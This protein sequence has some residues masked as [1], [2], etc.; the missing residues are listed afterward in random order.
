MK[1]ICSVVQRQALIR[2]WLWILLL[3]LCLPTA[4]ASVPF[5]GGQGT[6]ESPYQISNWHHLHAVR[7]YLDKSFILTAD[8][9]PGTE[10]YAERVKNGDNLAN[11]GRGWDPI[12]TNNA[13]NRFSGHFDGGGKTIEGLVL[14]APSSQVLGLFGETASDAVIKN[15]NLVNVDIDGFFSVGALVGVHR[16]VLEEVAA[17]GAV[18]GFSG[19]GGL[20]GRN[21][22]L[23][24]SS[25]A[26]ASV[27]PASG[28]TTLSSAGGAVGSNEASGTLRQVRA[29]SAVAAVAEFGG[30]V[31][32]NKGVVED[33]HA[34]GQVEG[35]SGT[36]QRVGGF[37]GV[38]EGTVRRSGAAGDVIGVIDVGGFVGVNSAG[39]IED[40]Y[41]TVS[42]NAVN[43]ARV[44]GFAGDNSNGGVIR[45]AYSAGPVSVTGTTPQGPFV[46]RNNGT[47]TASLWNADVNSGAVGSLNGGAIGAS[48][49]ELRSRSRFTTSFENNAWDFSAVWQIKEGQGNVFSFPYL[50]GVSYDTPF[51]TPSIHP[52][53]GLVNEPALILIF[54]TNKSAG[55]AIQ[56][57]FLGSVNVNID[58]GDG[59]NVQSVN[60]AGVVSRTYAQE[61]RYT[62]R[63]S[64]SLDHFGVVVSSDSQNPLAGADKLVQVFSF[65]NLGISSLEGAFFGAANLTQ[66]PVHL[67]ATVTNLGSAFERAAL[68]N[69]DL[70]VWDVSAVTNMGRMFRAASAF[71]GSGLTAWDIRG[72]VHLGSGTGLDQ[73]LSDTSLTRENYDAL[74]IAW[75][76][77]PVV[78]GDLVLG[79]VPTQYTKGP[80]SIARQALIDNFG[81]SFSDSSLNLFADG[82]GSETDPFQIANWAHLNAVRN[83]LESHFILNNDLDEAS[84]G[85]A[86]FVG[87]SEGWSPIGTSTQL[88]RGV[89]N[90]DGKRIRNLRSIRPSA[91]HVALFAYV[92]D[93]QIHDLGLLDVDVHG[94][95]WSASLAADV[96]G[97]SQIARVFA[98]GQ[99]KTQYSLAGGLVARCIGSLS[100]QPAIS[101]VYSLVSVAGGM[102]GGPNDPS[103]NFGGIAGNAP[104]CPIA[105][106]YSAGVVTGPNAVGGLVGGTVNSLISDSYWDVEASGLGVPN[107]NNAGAIGKTTSQMRQQETFAAWDF[108]AIWHIEAS[109][110]SGLRSYPRLRGFEY[111]EPF[112]AP[113]VNPIPGLVIDEAAM[114][115]R[116]DTNLGNGTTIELSLQG[117]VN[118][119]VD[120]GDGTK[121]VINQP[122]RVS[123]TYSSDGEYQVIILGTLTHFGRSGV[124]NATNRLP[125]TDML[126][127][128]V[129]FGDL[130]LESLAAAFLGAENLLGVAED[131]PLSVTNLR[132]AFEGAT[133]FNG[134]ITGWSVSNVTD[135]SRM[136]FGASSFN[137]PIG[138]WDVSN[139]T[140]FSSM[141]FEASSFNAN[142]ASWDVG[143]ATTFFSMFKGAIAFEGHGLAGWNT[144]SVT[145]MANMFYLA[146]KF[147]AD[148]ALWNVSKVRNMLGMFDGASEFDSVVTL[149]DVSNVT[150][151]SFMFND[152]VSFKG[153]GL[154][155]WD[156]SNVTDMRF[157]FKRATVLNADLSAWDVGNVTNMTAMFSLARQFNSD[158]GQWNVSQVTNMSGMFDSATAF[159][160]F[161]LSAWDIG[162]VAGLVNMLT[163]SALTRA[164]YDA[165]L[166]AWSQLPSV[167]I[168][169]D[170]GTVP[171]QYTVGPA[172]I[173][174]QALI[175]EFAWTIADNGGLNLFAAGTG[176]EAAPFL[177]ANWTQLNEVRNFPDAHF[178]LNG[179][180]DQGTP[181]YSAVVGHAD[182]WVPIGTPNAPF[183]S[184]FDGAGFEI[185]DLVINRPTQDNIGLF[186]VV[187]SASIKNL[188]LTD[189]DV[190]GRF[191]VGVLAGSVSGE[192]LI[193]GVRV[194]QGQAIG[195]GRVGGLVGRVAEQAT[196]QLS[197]ATGTVRGGRGVGGLIGVM[198]GDGLV[199]RSFATG[200][201]WAEIANS[202]GLIG[203][204][205]NLADLRETAEVRNVYATGQVSGANNAGGLIG[206][207][208]DSGNQVVNAWASGR[209]VASGDG[210]GL[211]G[212]DRRGADVFNSFWDIETA[213]L[214]QLGDDNFGAI[215]RNTA[216]MKLASQFTGWDFTSTGEWDIMGRESNFVSYPFLRG[217]NY[218][219]PSNSDPTLPIPGLQSVFPGSQLAIV[220][221]PIGG[222][223]GGVLA[224]QPVVQ[225]LDI[226]GQRATEST[227]VV[228]VAL[229][230]DTK[231][232]LGP[233]AALTA[234]AVD[235]VASFSGLQLAG[236]LDEDYQLIFSASG[237]S[238]VVSGT[239]SVTAGAP[240]AQTSTV[241]ASPSGLV[242]DGVSSSTITVTLRD[243]FGSR[244]EDSS[245]VVALSTTE[246]TVGSVTH[247]GEGIYTATLTAATSIGNAIVTASLNGVP[248]DAVAT[249]SMASGAADAAR[250]T[251]N[252]TPA[253]GLIANDVDQSVLEV[254][255][256]DSNG[257]PVSGQGVFL[258][259][260]EGQARID[261]VQLTTDGAG[262]AVTEVRSERAGDVILQ[263]YLG[264]DDQTIGSLIGQVTLEFVAGPPARLLVTSE[265]GGALDDQ[266]QN[267]PFD[268]RL[269]LADLFSN[270][271]SFSSAQTITLTA[272]DIGAA[273][274]GELRWAESET[275]PVTVIL[276][277]GASTVPVQS[278]MYTGLS[279]ELGRD[280][281]VE[282]SVGDLSGQSNPFSVRDSV[283]TIFAGQTTLVANGRDSTTVTVQLS[284]APGIV[285]ADQA[286]VLS[287]TR[288]ELIGGNAVGAELSLTTNSDGETIASLR[289]P[290]TPGPAMIS[291]EYAG[292]GAACTVTKIVNFVAAGMPPAPGTQL[293]MVIEPVTSQ[294][295]ELMSVQP[296]VQVLNDTQERDTEFNSPITVTLVSDAPGS[297]GPLSALTVSAEDGLATFS[298][299]RLSGLVGS[300]Y[301]LRFSA[302]GLAPVESGPL[303]VT[304]GAASAQTS[305]IA[306]NP[307]SVIA[308]GAATSIVTVTLRDAAGNQTTDNGAVVEI[309]ASKGTI[310]ITELDQGLGTATFVADTEVGIASINAKLNGVE[311]VS[312]DT[313]TM[314]A[315]PANAERST[316]TAAPGAALIAN[317]VD[318]SSLQVL[319][320]DVHGN[321]IS[322]QPVFLAVTSGEAQMV[323]AQL[324]T[325]LAGGASTTVTSTRSGE[326]IISA[327]LGSDD[328]NPA[329]EIGRV[330]LDFVAGPASQWVISSA[331]GSALADQLQNVPFDVRLTLTDADGN[332]A[333]V[334]QVL[335]VSLGVIGG[336]PSGA[337]QLG[338]SNASPV[339]SLAADESSVLVQSVFYTGASVESGPDIRLAA[340]VGSITGQSNLFSVRNTELS[341][342]IE[343]SSLVADGQATTVVTVR[344]S[345]AQGNRLAGQSIVLSTTQGLLTSG[346]STASQLSLTTNSIG[347]VSA[348]LR[349]PSVPGVA[350][351]SA[352][353]AG[354]CIASQVVT[355]TAGAPPQDEIFSDSFIRRAGQ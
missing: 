310:G 71:E 322:A 201:V 234:T 269:S 325:D 249:V 66:V 75:R 47:I 135:F 104:F 68:F 137:Q 35:V 190:S 15:L 12:G 63:V 309:T 208:S 125:G 279:N 229:V 332:M 58:W 162:S 37:V 185:A 51:A 5:A 176:T 46:G 255:V 44:A 341:I 112:A 195:E 242:A 337:L 276:P 300:E 272:S 36:P 240:S 198:D 128:V 317:G 99:V 339:I 347:E 6:P 43:G 290:A 199:E 27:M 286:I 320:V 261:A 194:K 20:V 50:Q 220:I 4:W 10:G 216:Q 45:R 196:V 301:R 321:P 78:P 206:L 41:A 297:L 119:S 212:L 230:D 96:S 200:E 209:V 256:V 91:S 173:A 226:Q 29:S 139:G 170:L 62:V 260:L 118:V 70:S 60:G 11:G 143:K 85:Y 215:G 48:E 186:G 274:P 113:A 287:T 103:N 82:D 114:V 203:Q 239:V 280:V 211:I 33:S 131:L 188:T 67:P 8:L 65:G 39:T 189:A 158:L 77:L 97:N 164:N 108:D 327:Y 222:A 2:S 13:N 7:E 252:A 278:V 57:S 345:D 163:G 110:L 142:L 344:F 352:A 342:M 282:A 193:Q 28:G 127:E 197:F 172:S 95:F 21:E 53:P 312:S 299:L 159:Q 174:R 258:L 214:G 340:S 254:L 328:Q 263:A 314:L 237:L 236:A 351:L 235:G 30:L 257:N 92:Q 244:T 117:S 22:G 308:N 306:A 146:K 111:D 115:L 140:I 17:S 54:D 122:G 88:F 273:V 171:S 232:T 219:A 64:G 74:L 9:G 293:A 107:G 288:G 331:D 157:M 93:A 19:V 284:G 271:V 87:G 129:T 106:A 204:M 180:L 267:A 175:D 18:R 217:I 72:L 134:D 132:A 330:V 38:N 243:A 313:V 124:V 346:S 241:T 355:F 307:R 183:T 24:E 238:S 270:P 178:A 89:F 116:F 210:G 295:G 90:G 333:K 16:G 76:Q 83:F 275:T 350:L 218:D 151:M 52:I 98:T 265:S 296:Q 233:P 25:D 94:I 34:A 246:G 289:A 319:V 224:T 221:E 179:D 205:G 302:D 3:S 121:E 120:W 155:N 14:S 266:V 326:V 303:S 335:D 136:F 23:V 153:V 167:P 145:N 248:L 79:P 213:S 343:E 154:G 349:A 264:T 59:S 329:S 156:V 161:G 150:N 323:D 227:A 169:L 292:C 130:G 338:G 141:F 225:V 305:T 259:L 49:L 40:S 84:A 102:A 354:A 138:V 168:G 80:A 353:C 126:V 31:G 1:Q 311:L 298:R 231:G 165:L 101:D 316:F 56:L 291:A 81:W 177:I 202:G 315:G 228:T 73:M 181:G 182:G 251:F 148:L 247:A 42:V 250:S 348:T 184:S 285:L 144:G 26:A 336:G 86:E 283:L 133:R 105:R 149:W 277:A 109:A 294:S 123:H 187:E 147:N 318:S 324:S 160:G 100:D 207:L 245:A 152:A 191:D 61:G 281:F 55:R 69:Q 268:L 223:S 253:G 262:Q 32:V 166:I 304:A 334:S 192:S